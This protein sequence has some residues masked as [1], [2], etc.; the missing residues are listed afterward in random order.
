MNL[1]TFEECAAALEAETATALHR[2]IYEYEPAKPGDLA[3]R[4]LLQEVLTV[5]GYCETIASR[6]G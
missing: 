4:N 5:T 1:P 6:S 2:F 3:F